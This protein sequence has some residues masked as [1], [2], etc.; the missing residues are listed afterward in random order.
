MD[1]EKELQR[2]EYQYEKCKLPP[3]LTHHLSGFLS[4]ADIEFR[5]DRHK[6][7]PQSFRVLKPAPSSPPGAGYLIGKTASLANL[8][9]GT[10]LML[11]DEYGDGSR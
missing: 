7:A 11:K 5:V 10:I 3:K 6:N 8:A 1:L 2:Y 4:M 9:P